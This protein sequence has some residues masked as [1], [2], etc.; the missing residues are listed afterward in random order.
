[1][2]DDGHFDEKV[3][4]TY[5]DDGMSAPEVVDPAVDLLAKLAGDG[6][7]L[8]FAI[9]TGR[10]ALPLARRGVQVEGIE[11]SRPMVARLRAKKGGAEIP[12]AVG[13]MATTRVAGRFSLV[14][15]VFNTINNL[16]SQD[17]QVACFGNAAAHL[18]RG[19][20]FLIEVG[21]PPLQRLP[22]GETI[23]AF[24]HSETHWG[25]DEF[26]VVSQNFSSHHIWLRNGRFERFSVPFRYAWPAEFDLMARLA[27]LTL[28]HR[29][30]GWKKEPFT[31]V[32]DKHISVWQKVG[33]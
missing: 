24:D 16:T 1:M 10:L 5:D 30:S 31:Q 25:L 6:R 8:E 17:A 27:G 4:A 23:L 19:G 11:L 33:G 15:L 12:V 28:Q 13:D 21:V 29:W 7:V 18:E 2:H 22:V 3:A 20:Y 32:S 14:Y 26:D 9:G